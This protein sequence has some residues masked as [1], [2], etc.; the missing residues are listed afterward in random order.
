MIRRPPLVCIR[1]F[2][3]RARVGSSVIPFPIP[4]TSHAACGFP[5]LRAP[6]RFASRVMGPIT[7]E[8]LSAQGAYS[9]ASSRSLGPKHPDHSAFTLTY[10][11]RLRSCRSMGAFIITP[12]PHMLT[13]ES[14]TAGSLCSTGVTPL[15]R[16]YGPG[17]HRLA[18]DRLP[19]VSGY[20]AYLPPPISRWGED[21]FSSCIACP[22]HRATPTTPPE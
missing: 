2:P 21:G 22:C 7:L 4:A 13:K 15:R 12:L 8:P 6:A 17:R 19:G 10:I 11:L 9:T 14:R 1:G 3:L 16:Y 18:F 5:A 20:T